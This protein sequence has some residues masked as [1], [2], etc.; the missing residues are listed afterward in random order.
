M[1]IK[2]T[3]DAPLLEGGRKSKKI[4]HKTA[5]GANGAQKPGTG[6][7]G[8]LNAILK[9]AGTSGAETLATH[10]AKKGR[11]AGGKNLEGALTPEQ[12]KAVLEQ[13]VT[14]GY[15]DIPEAFVGMVKAAMFQ[16]QTGNAL[17]HCAFG[18]YM[19]DGVRYGIPS[20][21][22]KLIPLCRECNAIARGVVDVAMKVYHESEA[23]ALLRGGQLDAGQKNREGDSPLFWA[24]S[25][26]HPEYRVMN[27]MRMEK[28]RGIAERY[29]MY[30]QLYRN[31]SSSKGAQLIRALDKEQKAVG[32]YYKYAPLNQEGRS[33]FINDTIWE[34]EY[35]KMEMERVAGNIRD[36]LP[37]H[38]EDRGTKIVA[39]DVWAGYGLRGVKELDGKQVIQLVL[40]TQDTLTLANAVRHVLLVRG[41][42]DSIT[43]DKLTF[44]PISNYYPL[45][46]LV[47]ER[48]PRG[49]GQGGKKNLGPRPF[50]KDSRHYLERA[51][52]I[53]GVR[54]TRN[55]K[56]CGAYVHQS[57]RSLTTLN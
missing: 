51:G 33:I 28:A 6:D 17:Q 32:E 27:P 40:V 20:P 44:Y 7:N 31:E 38:N 29:A 37:A 36:P 43:K 5:A 2:T 12:V 14:A 19:R 53:G 26:A 57:L 23:W 42:L 9:K 21:K 46:R 45:V 4:K 15:V 8:D 39:E 18:H 50:N 10:G 16:V 34:E 47:Q 35:A 54:I 24:F 25:D 30:F 3:S 11:R 48:F 41:E 55:H 22:G 56:R 52:P 13:S 49:G 1:V